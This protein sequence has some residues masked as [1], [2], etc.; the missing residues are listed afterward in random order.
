MKLGLKVTVVIRLFFDMCER[1]DMIDQI[2]SGIGRV[3]DEIMKGILPLL[4]ITLCV[5]LLFSEITVL[6][7]PGYS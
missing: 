6:F 4:S 7:F 2:G 3:K 1:I 5:A